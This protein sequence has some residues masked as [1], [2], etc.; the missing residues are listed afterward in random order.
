[1]R[2]AATGV[3]HGVT[4]PQRLVAAGASRSVRP[5][6]NGQARPEG[7]CDRPGC[8]GH[9]GGADPGPTDAPD[10]AGPGHQSRLR[11]GL[12]G[13]GVLGEEVVVGPQD[14]PVQVL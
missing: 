3:R 12:H 14:G 1:M 4:P 10:R 6:A 8:A 11:V 7:G 9:G 2:V 5:A 13:G